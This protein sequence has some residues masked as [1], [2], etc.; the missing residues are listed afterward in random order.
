MYRVSSNSDRAD[1]VKVGENNILIC[2][3]Q[4]ENNQASVALRC[5]TE[6]SYLRTFVSLAWVG[7]LSPNG[8]FVA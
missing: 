3:R 1:K 2:K 7:R 8:L 6:D 5:S 4:L